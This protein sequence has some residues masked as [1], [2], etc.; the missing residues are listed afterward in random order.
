MNTAIVYK[1][2]AA[3]I[4]IA[5]QG[6][7][8]M[9]RSL[10]NHREDGKLFDGEGKSTTWKW[11]GIREEAGQLYIK[12][13]KLELIS[14]TDL[15]FAGE[16]EK[17]DALH[18]ARLLYFAFADAG[19]SKRGLRPS[20]LQGCYFV[21]ESGTIT[22]VLMLP[23]LVR[24][25][26]HANSDIEESELPTTAIPEHEDA[27]L[28]AAFASAAVFFRL[29]SGKNPFPQEEYTS[30]YERARLCG[31]SY[32]ATGD[33]QRDQ[34][35]ALL[36]PLLSFNAAKEKRGDYSMEESLS[37]VD[38]YRKLLKGADHVEGS[39]IPRPDS[40]E[41]REYKRSSPLR[42]RLFFR[43]NRLRFIIGGIS[44]AIVAFL[45]SI[46]G[47]IFFR[48]LPT[49]G[50]PPEDV[51]RL[52]YE[53]RNSL[54]HETLEA[55]LHGATGSSL[56]D[57]ITTLFVI[58]RVRMGYE[59]K[60]T[61]VP[62]SQWLSH[63]DADYPPDALIYGTAGIRQHFVERSEEEALIEAEVL[64][65]LP[66]EGEESTGEQI[67]LKKERLGLVKS[68]KRW[69]ID[70]IETVE[71]RELSLSAALDYLSALTET[72]Q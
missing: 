53:S 72:M 63:A 65:I 64:H 55:C 54:D 33:H 6:G 17:Q 71:S 66:R 48:E 44:L 34:I 3:L 57:E 8:S 5:P 45:L 13:A 41:K 23:P 36:D 69:E 32:I 56:V 11:F 61:F 42:R 40:V 52:F 68:P 35:L 9:Q 60:Q 25:I 62:A 1:E 30:P 20:D 26:I 37:A 10:Q 70:S 31:P 15:V 21:R 29:L 27:D 50:L 19:I 16:R 12:G 49:D 59:Q 51:A 38:S 46:L 58:H 67:V 24:D 39:S 4:P 22:R 7:A 2:D 47:N 14:A 28:R 43:R 18:L